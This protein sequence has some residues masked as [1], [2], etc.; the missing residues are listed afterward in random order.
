MYS[1]FKA[2]SIESS[3][4]FFHQKQNVMYPYTDSYF[5]DQRQMIN[6][7]KLGQL[8]SGEIALYVSLKESSLTFNIGGLQM[9]FY[10]RLHVKIL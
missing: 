3:T 8:I 2:L 5:T 4:R 1:S 10:L 6:V 7:K 9:S